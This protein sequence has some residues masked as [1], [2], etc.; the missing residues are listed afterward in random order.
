MLLFLGLC[1]VLS[2]SAKEP[3]NEEYLKIAKEYLEISSMSQM[4]NQAVNQIIDIYLPEDADPGVRERV[5]EKAYDGFV[6]YIAEIY[7][8]YIDIDDLRKS[9]EFS[10]SPAGKRIMSA[11]K[12]MVERSFEMGQQWAAD[13][14][15]M[16]GEELAGYQEPPAPAVSE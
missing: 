2:V 10:R 15:E 12:A 11:Q 13:V 9:M 14:M 8:E 3:V 5:Y 1:G 16:I 7:S 4:I 6:V